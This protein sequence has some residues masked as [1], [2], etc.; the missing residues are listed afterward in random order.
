M[1]NQTFYQQSQWIANFVKISDY[2]YLLFHQ[3]NK[4]DI[5]IIFEDTVNKPLKTTF[6]ED[7]ENIY[8]K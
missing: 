5:V 3:D 4:F 7:I 8:T 6:K 2:Y 1:W